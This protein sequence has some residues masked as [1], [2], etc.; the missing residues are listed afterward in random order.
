MIIYPISSLEGCLP[1]AV[2]SSPSTRHVVRGASSLVCF[3]RCTYSRVNFNSRS[4]FRTRCLDKR[5]EEVASSRRP[6]GGLIRS[7]LPRINV[8]RNKAREKIWQAR[9]TPREKLSR[10]IAQISLPSCFSVN[11]NK[12]RRECEREKIYSSS[13]EFF[14]AV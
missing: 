8:E 14:G 2:S 10:S 5:V 3:T 7:R 12:L 4:T 9:Q 13:L 11:L 1:R 6:R